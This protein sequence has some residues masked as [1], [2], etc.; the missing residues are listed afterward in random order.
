[1]NDCLPEKATLPAFICY[2][3]FLFMRDDA[4]GIR[5]E[6]GSVSLTS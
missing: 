1:M 5:A 2:F 3:S 6:V 4:A